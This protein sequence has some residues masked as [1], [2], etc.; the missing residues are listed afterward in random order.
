METYP[1][2]VEAHPTPQDGEF[3]DDRLYR[4]S[5]RN[6]T[7][8]YGSVVRIIFQI[9]VVTDSTRGSCPYRKARSH[10]GMVVVS[11]FLKSMAQ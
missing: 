4:V 1:V 11:H 3:L 9:L 2:E 7:K 5:G 8:T 6:Q 10:T